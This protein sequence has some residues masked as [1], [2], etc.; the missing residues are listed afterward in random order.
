MLKLFL[1]KQRPGA[2]TFYIISNISGV[3]TRE[4]HQSFH[5]NVGKKVNKHIHKMSN[6]SFNPS[7]KS[8]REPISLSACKQ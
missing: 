2:V 3:Q 1:G 6:C 4:W 7:I 5:L 8:Q